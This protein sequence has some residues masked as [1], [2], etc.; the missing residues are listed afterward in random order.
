MRLDASGYTPRAE[1]ARAIS[2]RYGPAVSQ[3]AV[4][5]LLDRGGAV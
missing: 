1:V 4:S 5:A 2:R 3:D